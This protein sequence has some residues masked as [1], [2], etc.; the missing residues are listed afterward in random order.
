M[1]VFFESY[2]HNAQLST[3]LPV[4][5]PAA[6]TDESQSYADLMWA[7]ANNSGTDYTKDGT[8][9][10]VALTFGH[11]LSKLTMNCTV[12]ASVG[13]YLQEVITDER[14]DRYVEDLVNSHRYI[15]CDNA[16]CRS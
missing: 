2:T 14:Y 13:L 3:A 4:A 10:P 11:C 1:Q 7:K 6:Q 15:D 12:D 5:I 9:A 8:T 16:V